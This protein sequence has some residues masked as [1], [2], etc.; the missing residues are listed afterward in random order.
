MT[1]YGHVFTKD[2]K[3]RPW[4]AAIRAR[5]LFAEEYRG[6]LVRFFEIASSRGLKVE[7]IF[8]LPKPKTKKA[9]PPHLRRPDLDNLLKAAIDAFAEVGLPEDAVV[10]EIIARK[11][12]ASEGREPGMSLRLEVESE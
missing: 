12:T 5:L 8:V 6:E 9:G 4:K 2:A 10:V 11:V 7:A 3:V 1:R